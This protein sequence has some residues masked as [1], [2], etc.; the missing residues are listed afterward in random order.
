MRKRKKDKTKQR[1]ILW[2]TLVLA[3]CIWAIVAPHITPNDPYYSNLAVAKQGPSSQY[4]LG[5]DQLGR[6]MLSRIMAGAPSTI[7]SAIAVVMITFIAGSLI[8]VF[9]GYYGGR[10]DAVVMRIVDMF[11][12]FPGIVL[13]IAVAG[14]LG[15]GMRNAVIALSVVGWTQYTRLARSRVLAMR[16]ELFMKAAKISGSSDLKIIFRHV[17]PN[18]MSVLVVTAALSIG[19]NIM[20]MA[21]LSFLGL[22]AQSPKAEWGVMMNEGRSLLQLYPGMILY[23]GIFIFV[24]V[25]L[26]NLFGDSVRDM[27]DPRQ[28]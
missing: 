4:P 11:Q 2:S 17:L 16:E 12:A 19:G 25:M 15:A 24:A 1:L 5:T 7:F 9:C 22:G 8:G 20:E 3:L 14:I 10:F 26:F 21:S 28:K 27:L 23:P 13:A 18:A 6:C